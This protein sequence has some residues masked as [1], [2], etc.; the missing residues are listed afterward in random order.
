MKHW[1]QWLLVSTNSSVHTKGAIVSMDEM[2]RSKARCQCNGDRQEDAGDKHDDRF[3]LNEW[4][5]KIEN[6]Q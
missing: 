3:V 4:R 1:L 2:S 5:V 6:Q